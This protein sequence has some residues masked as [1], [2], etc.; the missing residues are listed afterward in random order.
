MKA[1]PNQVRVMI[2][3]GGWWHAF[4]MFLG[5]AV[6][7]GLPGLVF[8]FWM[9]SMFFRETWR[10]RVTPD[11]VFSGFTSAVFAMAVGYLVRN[12]FDHLYADF[13]ALLFWILIA[14][15]I[16]AGGEPAERPSEALDRLESPR[17]AAENAP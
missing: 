5:V 12:W 1:Y 4:N 8:F 6:G 14:M 15:A 9:L 10:A 11:L 3:E 7:L 16:A 13:P 2:Q 17:I